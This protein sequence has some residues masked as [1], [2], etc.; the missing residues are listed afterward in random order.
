MPKKE[1]EIEYPSDEPIVDAL[2]NACQ[3]F[4]DN[5]DTMS[6]KQKRK[7]VR[8]IIQLYCQRVRAGDLLPPP[9]I[10]SKDGFD[11]LVEDEIFEWCGAIMHEIEL[12]R[13]ARYV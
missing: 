6:P 13:D 5:H 3:K 1:E 10:D 4:I 7:T 12:R 9:K 8:T 11:V 2:Y